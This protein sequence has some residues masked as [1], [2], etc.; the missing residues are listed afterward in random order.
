MEDPW[1]MPARVG[2]LESGA[3]GSSAPTATASRYGSCQRSAKA[4]HAAAPG[5][6]SRPRRVPLDCP[7][8]RSGA[9]REFV[10][11]GMPD[12]P[13]ASIQLSA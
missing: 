3:G 9:E 8:T 13:A 7:S 10:S 5:G 12:V 11:V 1:P 6:S 2:P 4:G